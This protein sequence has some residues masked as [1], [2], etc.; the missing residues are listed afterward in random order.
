MATLTLNSTALKPLG[1]RV[2]VRVAD[3]EEKTSGGILLP[4]SSKEKPQVGEIA[5]VGPGSRGDDGEPKSL[6]VKVG[7]RVLYSK[8]AGT[9]LKLSGED[10][11][12]LREQDVLA[13]L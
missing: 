12:L 13:T 9:D 3:A 2:L 10:Y 1:D 4:D 7:D 8:Y 6:D 11:V 5:A